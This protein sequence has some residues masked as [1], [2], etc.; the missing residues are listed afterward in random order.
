MDGEKKIEAWQQELIM[1]RSGMEEMGPVVIGTISSSRKKYR[2]KDGEVRVCGDTA[3]LKFAGTGKNL[4]VRIPKDKEKLVRK[5][6]DNGRKWRDLNKRYILLSSR[7]AV[8]GALKK[9]LVMPTPKFANLQEILAEESD[10]ETGVVSEKTE[11]RLEVEMRRTR[12]DFFGQFFHGCALFHPIEGSRG[13]RTETILTR[14]GKVRVVRRYVIKNKERP[15]FVGRVGRCTR[16]CE[17]EVAGEGCDR[18][19]FKRAEAVARSR[20]IDISASKIR[21]VTLRRGKAEY[22]SPTSAKID[23]TPAAACAGKRRRT[24]ATMVVSTDGTCAP[25]AKKD[26]EGVEGRDGNPATGRNVD[27]GMV[28]VYNS[29]RREDNRPVIPPSS[30][31]Y[32]I[33]AN[34]DGMRTRLRETA[35]AAG[36]GA[37]PRVQF[38]GDGAPWIENIRNDSFAKAVFT[39]DC[40]HAFGS[41]NKVCEF[42]AADAKEAKKIFRKVKDRMYEHDFERAEKYLKNKY[43]AWFSADGFKQWDEGAMKAWKYLDARRRQMNYGWLRRHGYLIGSGHIESACKVVCGLRRTGVGG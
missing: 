23:L 5:M 30:R 26:L 16:A 2:T 28:A 11:E 24:K 37:M 19:S 12:I 27:V 14:F 32:V 34:A 41:V 10:A 6:I 25:C 4:T 7:L 33:A 3:V 8:Y 29:V 15:G 21:E 13:M 36:Y 38:I 42:L 17:I 20:G 22:E 31:K 9:L 1:V 39:L 40:S 35:L 18:S 43:K